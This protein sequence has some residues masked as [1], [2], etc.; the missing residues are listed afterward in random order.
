MR[1]S[2][3]SMLLDA[4]D[5]CDKG[6]DGSNALIYAKELLCDGTTNFGNPRKVWD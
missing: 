6:N 2:I 5:E 1:L 3:I 4:S